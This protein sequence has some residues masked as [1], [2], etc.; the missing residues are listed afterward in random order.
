MF[1]FCLSTHIFYYNWAQHTNN[2]CVEEWVT[3]SLGLRSV[4]IA[5]AKRD[6]RLMENKINGK[7]QRTHRYNEYTIFGY[8]YECIIILTRTSIYLLYNCIFWCLILH[9]DILISRLIRSFSIFFF[10]F[11]NI[12]KRPN[13]LWFYTNI[14]N[15]CDLEMNMMTKTQSTT[16]MSTA[17]HLY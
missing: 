14:P 13:L 9:I 8:V 2:F 15:L 12:E 5:D 17:N 10:Y 11:F 7:R 4:V 1:F 6:N 3:Y 16:T